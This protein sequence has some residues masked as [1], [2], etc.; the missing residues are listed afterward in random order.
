MPDMENFRVYELTVEVLRNTHT[1]RG[2]SF[3]EGAPCMSSPIHA[4]YVDNQCKRVEDANSI[5]V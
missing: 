1:C 2:G 4:N 3:V 5:K